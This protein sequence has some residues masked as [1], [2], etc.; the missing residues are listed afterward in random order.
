MEDLTLTYVN[1][2]AVDNLSYTAF[3]NFR[4]IDGLMHRFALFRGCTISQGG[5]HIPVK[6]PL[7]YD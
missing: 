6:F 5:F 2:F 1:Q 7:F 3:D 4:F